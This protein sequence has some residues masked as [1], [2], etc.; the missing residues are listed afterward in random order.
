M[1][2]QSDYTVAPENSGATLEKGDDMRGV[3]KVLMSTLLLLPALSYAGAE[4]NAPQV[5]HLLSWTQGLWGL[6]AAVAVMLLGAIAGV[7]AGT[8]APPLEGIALAAALNWLPGLF[9]SGPPFVQ[10]LL[11]LFLFGWLVS[12][13]VMFSGLVN[14]GWRDW[15]R[16][17]FIEL[18]VDLVRKLRRAAGS[19]FMGK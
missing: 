13:V 1:A 16:F 12:F 2:A 14:S 11:A 4:G 6:G 8:P 18:S 19:R 7:P 3:T 17:S 10:N 15:R 5:T 9:G